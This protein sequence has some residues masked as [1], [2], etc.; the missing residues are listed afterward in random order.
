MKIVGITIGSI[1]ALAFA[2]ILPLVWML[3]IFPLLGL[4]GLEMNWVAGKIGGIDPGAIL[5]A[6]F[7]LAL[8]LYLA[9]CLRSEHKFFGY[10]LSISSILFAIL[11]YALT[12]SMIW[13]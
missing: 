5:V 7:Y 12:S 10:G 2:I 13:I 4:V 11:S 8:C 6:I 1:L 3:L 9:Y